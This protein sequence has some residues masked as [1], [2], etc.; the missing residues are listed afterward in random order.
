MKIQI[1]LDVSG[2]PIE[3]AII[4]APLFI[5][6]CE[7]EIYLPS[8]F[9]DYKYKVCFISE[10]GKSIFGPFSNGQK[11]DFRKISGRKINVRAILDKEYH[12]E[13]KDTIK[14]VMNS[15]GEYCPFEI[16]YKYSG[17]I[18]IDAINLAM[19]TCAFSNESLLIERAKS[20]MEQVLRAVIAQVLSQ[21]LTQSSGISAHLFY[22]L[23]TTVALAI[24]NTFHEACNQYLIWCKPV[25][26]LKIENTNMNQVIQMLNTPIQIERA[27]EEQRFISDL[28]MREICATSLHELEKENIRAIAQI[29]STGVHPIDE[30]RKLLR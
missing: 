4:D 24:S 6:N 17:I 25:G 11:F 19:S 18:D 14:S 10:D 12:I 28:K 23:E 30:L 5:K 15:F 13:F 29:G 26:C 8:N 20:I 22:N 2:R 9:R 1:I 16:T 3:D 21:N 7:I 27:R